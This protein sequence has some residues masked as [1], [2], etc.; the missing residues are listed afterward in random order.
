MTDI[1]TIIP[2]LV[3]VVS[4]MLLLI[5][6]AMRGEKRDMKNLAIAGGVVFVALMLVAILAPSH[7]VKAFG[8][9]VA[10]DAFTKFSKI[11][12]LLASVFAFYLTYGYY[13][14][15]KKERV[16]ELPVLMLLSVVGMLLMVSANSL[17]SLYMALELQSL[18]LYVMAAVQR[19]NGKSSEAGLKYFVLGALASGLVLYGA[20]L[21]YGF[22]GTGNFEAIRQLYQHNQALP[23]GVLVGLV[24]LLT[25]ICF[26]VSA[27]PFHMWTPD[28]YEG[29]PLPV[30][31]FFALAPKIAA[32]VLFVRVVLM[33][34]ADMVT[35]WQQII[36]VVS[37]LSMVV[38]ALGA[39]QQH[40][41]KR[42]I[43][44]S[45]IGHVGYILVGLAAANADGV[46]GILLY[47]VI[48]MTLSAGMFACIMMIKRKDG[49]SEEIASLSGLVKNR[50]Y[51]AMIIAI[52]ML[53]MAGIPPFAG[54]FGKFFVFQA[55]VKEGLYVLT[56]I[57]VLSSVVAAF[58]YLRIIKIM[59]FDEAS[60]SLDK[61]AG[62][63]MQNVAL[64]TAV[65]N[66]FFF[67][68]FTFLVQVADKAAAAMF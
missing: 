23:V 27:V 31:T 44:Y 16:A 59:F 30:T 34:F 42:L 7:A 18:P 3:L 12:V 65:F 63:E 47:L 64:V 55:A 51:L 66:V 62:M 52:I 68:A 5:I 61:D 28:V 2:E 22:S 36:I 9:N 17:L 57:G 49:K 10:F 24:F 21:I 15:H 25:G 14:E 8:G 53:S 60:V 40:N 4:A 33:P 58:Y 19:D 46:R 26:K 41:I 37:A 6:G 56:V 48:Y 45:S 13:R 54:F 43:A 1:V 32:V 50:P 38:G 35:Q 11:L 67:V 20:S 39:I 29:S